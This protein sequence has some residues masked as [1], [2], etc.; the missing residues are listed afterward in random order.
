MN[1]DDSFKK[2]QDSFTKDVKLS[3]YSWF[4][5]GG[6]AEYF[7]K[8]NDK[9]QLIEFLAKAKS[10]NLKTTIIG[11]GSNTLFR[12]NGVKGV[13]GLLITFIKIPQYI[14]GN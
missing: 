10:K 12:D 1:L 5:L 4:N 11:A 7:Y 3:N 8:A 14:M 9:E 2:F 6:N 13:I